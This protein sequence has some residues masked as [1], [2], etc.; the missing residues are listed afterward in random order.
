LSEVADKLGGTMTSMRRPIPVK[1]K[2]G[3]R[4]LY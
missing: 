1:A 4:E 3:D 2:R